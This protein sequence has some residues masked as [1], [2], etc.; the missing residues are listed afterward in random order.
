MSSESGK[1]GDIRGLPRGSESGS[2]G[3]GMFPRTRSEKATS[4]ED[5]ERV[6]VKNK[7]RVKSKILGNSD[8][9]DLMMVSIIIY[10]QSFAD[11]CI[12][13]KKVCW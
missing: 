2:C 1:G 3:L 10:C 11:D 4:P 5:F 13:D 7:L 8:V 12:D 6:R 9:G